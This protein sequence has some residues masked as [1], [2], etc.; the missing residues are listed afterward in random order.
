M[1][2]Q[3]NMNEIVTVNLTEFGVNVL[4]EKHY[5]FQRWIKDRNARHVIKDFIAPENGMYT[6]QMWHLFQ[7]FGEHMGMGKEMPFHTNIALHN[8]E[9]EVE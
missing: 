7:D 1:R 9:G 6:V 2:A 5:G 8:V 4:R 3:M